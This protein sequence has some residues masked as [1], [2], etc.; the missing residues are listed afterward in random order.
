MATGIGLY[1]TYVMRMVNS[2]ALGRSIFRKVEFGW[3]PVVTGDP[4]GWCGRLQET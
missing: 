2:K 1:Q 3:A 4:K